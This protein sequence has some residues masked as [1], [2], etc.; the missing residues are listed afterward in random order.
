MRAVFAVGREAALDVIEPFVGIEVELPANHLPVQARPVAK[1]D[2]TKRRHDGLRRCAIVQKWRERL[3][4]A[5]HWAGVNGV[6][7]FPAKESGEPG[8]LLVS[9]RR[10]IH[11]NPAAKRLVVTCLDLAMAN[12]P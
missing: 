9:A 5:L 12:Q 1:V 7:L 6:E 8:G 2:F 11:V 4:D 10:K 3:L